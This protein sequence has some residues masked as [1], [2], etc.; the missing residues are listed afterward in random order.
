M[1]TSTPFSGTVHNLPNISPT[2]ELETK[3]KSLSFIGREQ[4]KMYDRRAQIEGD[5]WSGWIQVEAFIFKSVFSDNMG[6]PLEIRVNPEFGTEA[7]AKE[8]ALRY[9][10]ILGQ[11]PLEFR[12]RLEIMDLN[13]GTW[14]DGGGG[15]GNHE[16]KSLN[17]NTGHGEDMIEKKTIHNFFIHELCH[18]TFDYL[19]KDKG[20]WICAQNN[21]GKFIS[22]Y[23]RDS[24]TTEDIAESLTAWY[25]IT[26]HPD[27]V[28][29]EKITKIQETIPH[30]LQYC[31][32]YI[33]CWTC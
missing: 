22:E 1:E 18:V 5:P 10:Q 12:A 15:G 20:E 21:D 16:R 2:S 33:Q 25:L 32:K 19:H 8:Q 28:S 7:K 11:S 30:R 14:S 23:A 26:F 27:S 31:N 24:P 17:L 29:K 9:S 13:K 6:V 4:R 3:F